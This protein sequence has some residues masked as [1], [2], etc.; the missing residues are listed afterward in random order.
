MKGTHLEEIARVGVP[1][2][3]ANLQQLGE[4]GFLSCCHQALDLC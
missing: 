4:E 2:E 3:E 1:M